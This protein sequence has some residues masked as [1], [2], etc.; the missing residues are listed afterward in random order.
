[1][2]T[3]STHVLD[4]ASG[5][6]AAG[7]AV[8]LLAQGDELF[9]GITNEDGRC[10]GLAPLSPGHYRLTF[11]VAEYY[12]KQGTTLPDPPFLEVVEIAFGVA[13]PEGHYHVP[14]IVSPFSYS[15][16]RGS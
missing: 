1:M 16:Y 12:R 9:S 15:T 10:A 2:T 11:G 8:R 13:E 5:K 3:L 6:P 4:V 14:L 7:M